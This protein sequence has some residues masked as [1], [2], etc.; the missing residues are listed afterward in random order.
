MKKSKCLLL[1]NPDNVDVLGTKPASLEW[2]T[3]HVKQ[4][5]GLNVGNKV[6]VSACEQYLTK[7]DIE[8]ECH[9][10]YQ[11]NPE[12]AKDKYDYI[13][14]PLANI[15][16]YSG[17]DFLSKLSDWIRMV[18][19]PVYVLGCGIQCTEDNEI[20]ELKK[21]IGDVTACLIDNIYQNG[22]AVA[23]RGYLT[24]EYLDLCLKNE[25]VVTG[26]PSL[27]RNGS[28]HKLYR[29]DVSKED[30][31]VAFTSTDMPVKIYDD[32]IKRYKSTK[33]FDQGIIA[34]LYLSMENAEQF[35][36]EL[37]MQYGSTLLKYM[38]GDYM[39]YPYD[40]PV[41]QNELRN[42]HFAIGSRI[43]GCIT[44]MQASVPTK[45]ITI[46]SRVRELAEFIGLPRTNDVLQLKADLYDEYNQ[47]DFGEFNRK[48]KDGFQVFSDFMESNKISH[49]ID[50]K[51]LWEEKMQ[52]MIWNKVVLFDSED[53][54]LIRKQSAVV[55]VFKRKLARRMKRTFIRGV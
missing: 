17:L 34:G 54:E 26:C 21:N 13:V 25:A 55:S 10:F 19:K 11:L 35:V 28:K 20:F 38:V 14:A 16:N 40:I 7:P 27:Y 24:K 43:H 50:D 6:F 5:N 22:G 32:C 9:A 51:S 8:Y 4:N 23:T 3:E 39:V 2:V 44:A 30:F 37:E 47:L 15:F 48:Y 18:R 46:D 36:N 31:S 45:V 41:W 33:I 52:Q 29:A 42:H 49:D 1:H 12:V 53:I